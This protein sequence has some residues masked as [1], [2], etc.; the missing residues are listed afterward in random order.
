[1]IPT[2]ARRL[3][4][5]A[6][7]AS[8]APS[9]RARLTYLVHLHDC[10]KVNAGFQARS[11]PS[12]RVVGHIAPLAVLFGR[13]ADAH[14]AAR[15]HDALRS[16]RLEAWGAGCDAL[17]DAILSHHG[18]PWPRDED[19]RHELRHWRPAPSGYDP[20]DALGA[21]R[22]GRR[23]LRAGRVRRAGRRAAVRAWF[24][25]RRRWPGAAR[26]L[27]R[28]VGVEARAGRRYACDVVADAASRDRPR[29]AD[30]RPTLG[31]AP[32]AFDA[33]FGYR[34]YPHQER[35]ARVRGR[36]VVIESETGSGKTEAALWRF[37]ALFTRGDVDG[38]YF[39]L[40]TRTAAVQL[41]RRVEAF[42]ARLWPDEAPPAVLAVPGYLDEASTDEASTADPACRGDAAGVRSARRRGGRHARGSRLGVGAPEALLRRRPRRRDGRSGAARGAA[43]QARAPAR[44]A[45]HAPPA[46]RRR[47]ARVGRVH[48]PPAGTTA[49][50]PPRRGRTRGAARR[51]R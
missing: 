7:V 41:H 21:L 20:I 28:L 33:L 36:L 16:E 22:A 42:A 35:A 15:V 8:L 43:R 45:A 39:A 27:D 23:P 49:A 26:R 29:R 14:L 10:G 34:P 11:E 4:R 40:P 46:R 6:G 3:A 24:R 30:L 32:P 31:D 19:R 47:G 50:G 17:F 25:A 18:K 51:R 44:R 2:Y 9:L 13:Y 37:A 48:A 12:A 38:L 5:L 1:M